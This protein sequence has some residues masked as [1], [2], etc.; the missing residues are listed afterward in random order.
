MVAKKLSSKRSRELGHS[1]KAAMDT[2]TN[3]NFSRPKTCLTTSFSEQ[4]N[5]VEVLDINTLS[6]S[7]D[8]NTEDPLPSNKMTTRPTPA[9]VSSDPY[10]L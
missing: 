2:I 7:K 10:C 8:N 9:C 3:K 1:D 5:H 4:K 6:S